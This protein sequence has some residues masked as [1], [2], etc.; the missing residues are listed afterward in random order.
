MIHKSDIYTAFGKKIPTDNNIV[1][2]FI[3]TELQDSDDSISIQITEELSEPIRTD[4]VTN[5]AVGEK[6]NNI[7]APS[8]QDYRHYGFLRTAIVLAI[9][10][11]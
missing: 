9:I 7:T 11:L 2:P 5:D 8:S 4:D 6:K 1:D 3:D 10:V